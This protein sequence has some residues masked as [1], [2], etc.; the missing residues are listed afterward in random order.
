MQET[1]PS[2]EKDANAVDKNINQDDAQHMV[3][4]VTDAASPTTLKWYTEWIRA[5][6]SVPMQKKIFMS[7]NLAWKR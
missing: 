1:Q 5:A 6:W 4:D 2:P 7:R 3:K